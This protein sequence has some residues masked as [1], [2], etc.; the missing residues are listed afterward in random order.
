MGEG[1][2]SDPR[3]GLINKIIKKKIYNQNL[4]LNIN[5]I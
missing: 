2:V 1:G 5:I 3:T 4:Y